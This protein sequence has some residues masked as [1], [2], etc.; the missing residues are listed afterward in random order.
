MRVSGLTR[1]GGE[2]RPH[3]ATGP[4]APK[5][6]LL[7]LTQRI[8][9]PPTKGEKIRPFHL[10]RYLAAEFELHVGCL[11]DNPDDW[12]HVGK[13]RDM[14]RTTYFARLARRRRYTCLS[15]L[16]T[17]EPLSFRFFWDSG[18]ARWVDATL[19]QVR[20][21]VT[22]VCSTNMA[23]YVLDHQ[24]RSAALLVDYADVD[25]EKWRAYAG[26]TRGPMRWVYRREA[27]KVFR[28]EKRIAAAADTVS[29]RTCS[30]ARWITGRTSMRS[31]GLPG[32]YCRAYDSRVGMRGSS[33]LVRSHQVRF[34][35]WRP[36]RAWW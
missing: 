5:P 30:P 27:D 34:S 17:G 29:P 21:V 9:Y 15:G 7:F 23:P 14:A 18:L 26:R 33:S 22:F 19:S 6:P 28:E 25:S 10:L 1:H 24:T 32:I 13:I 2:A 11:I 8:P 3:V 31:F 4:G 12:Q 20:P 36:V 35:R 16:I